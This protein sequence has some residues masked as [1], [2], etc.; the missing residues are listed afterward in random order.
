MAVSGNHGGNV[1]FPEYGS[2]FLGPVP[3]EKEGLCMQ[4]HVGD[5][6]RCRLER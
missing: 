4:G 2:G 5:R 6:G 3:G 1:Y